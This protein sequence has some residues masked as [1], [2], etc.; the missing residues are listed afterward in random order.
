MFTYY[1]W[2]Y[3]ALPEQG[4]QTGELKLHF[5]VQRMGYPVGLYNFI[6]TLKAVFY[7]L[8]CQMPLNFATKA[9]SYNLA[10]F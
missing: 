1:F 3:F 5:F 10:R 6:C 9:F 4:Q 2:T 7:V 8:C